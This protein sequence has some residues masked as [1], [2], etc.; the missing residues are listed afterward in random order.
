MHEQ[1]REH[2]P[3]ISNSGSTSRPHKLLPTGLWPRPLVPQAVQGV[4]VTTAWH[5]LH[6]VRQAQCC[7]PV[8]KKPN[9]ATASTMLSASSLLLVGTLPRGWTTGCFLTGVALESPRPSP[10]LSFPVGN[11]AG[12]QH[13]LEPGL[14]GIPRLCGL[15][16]LRP[17]AAPLVSSE[18]QS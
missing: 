15:G 12:A 2:Q 18:L 4:T 16:A 9:T 10:Y 1:T 3:I 13:T 8:M 11:R 7:S 14:F 6:G 5:A 17:G